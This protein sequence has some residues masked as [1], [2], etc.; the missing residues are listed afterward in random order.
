M[1]DLKWDSAALAEV[2][3]ELRS[4]GD[5][6]TLIECKRAAGGVPESLGE[7][8]CAFANMPSG[9]TIVLGVDEVANFE[10]SGVADAGAMEKAI[11]SLCRQAVA[12]APQLIFDHVE[13][14]GLTVL[15]VTVVALLASEKPALYRGR[16]YLRQADGDYVMNSNDVR[17][18]ELAKFSAHDIQPADMRILPGVDRDHLDAGLTADFMRN[19]R[20]GMKRIGSIEEDERVLELLNVLSG[21]G[22]VRVAGLYA[23]GFFPQSTFPALGATAAVRLSSEAGAARTKNLAHFSGPLPILV[24]DTLEW[25]RQNIDTVTVYDHEGNLR[26]RPEFPLSAVREALSNAFV[27]RDV[28][29]SLDAG[30]QVEIRLTERALVIVS[31]GGLKGLTV[32]QLESPELSKVPVNQRLYDIAQFLETEDGARVVE[33]EGGGIGIMLAAVHEAGLHKPLLIDEGTAF[34]VIFPRVPRLNRKDREYIDGIP[35]RFTPLQEDILLAARRG[36]ASSVASLRKRYPWHSERTLER[37]IKELDRRGL[38][39]G[40]RR[41]ETSTSGKPSTSPRVDVPELEAL[42]RNVPVVFQKL[43]SGRLHSIATLAAATELSDGQVRYALAP[44]LE[45]GIVGMDGG[46]GKPTTYFLR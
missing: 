15:V 22:N 32:R 5:D 1:G 11:V 39:S 37:N 40:G 4:F 34:K 33:G 25:V 2:L 36:E 21:D 17:M 7:T 9:G 23:L 24:E 38:L 29:V 3:A 30:K 35:G 41:D 19:A 6:T 31:P 26:N 43:Q 20:A 42:G 14:E 16:A 18:L 12:P 28:S 45:K 13:L 27:H 44:L 46:R 8:L 10:I